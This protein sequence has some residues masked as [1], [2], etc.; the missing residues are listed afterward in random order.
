MYVI[1]ATSFKTAVLAA[2]FLVFAMSLFPIRS[3]MFRL[4]RCFTGHERE[5]GR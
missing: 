3:F 5:R 1:I 2:L 4:N